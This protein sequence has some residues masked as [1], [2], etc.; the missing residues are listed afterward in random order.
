ML[1]AY[2]KTNDLDDA[3]QTSNKRKT[4]DG[5]FCSTQ[6]LAGNGSAEGGWTTEEQ[7]C[8]SDTG[9][10]WTGK[11]MNVPSTATVGRLKATI[12]VEDAITAFVS[13]GLVKSDDKFRVQ[14]TF[15]YARLFFQ[16]HTRH[17]ILKPKNSQLRI[18]SLHVLG[19]GSRDVWSLHAIFLHA[20]DPRP[21]QQAQW[22]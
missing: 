3:S 9:S 7:H 20:F 2:D 5:G 4:Q 21:S 18:Y 22:Q 1:S 11:L 17:N 6:S 13:L 12:Q 16:H 19:V 14:V 10:E 8:D 15:S